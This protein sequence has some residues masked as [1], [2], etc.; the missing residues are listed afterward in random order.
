[1]NKWESCK[2]CLDRHPACWSD[3]ERYKAELKQYREK[4]E[5]LN[6]GREAYQFTRDTYCKRQGA[7]RAQ[8][9][10]KE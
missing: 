1:M 9:A 2:N 10:R 3:C 6:S 5:F 7:L 8:K 4:V